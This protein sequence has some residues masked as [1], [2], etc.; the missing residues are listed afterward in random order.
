MDFVESRINDEK[1]MMEKVI[2]KEVRGVVYKLIN[3]FGKEF[4]SVKTG[5]LYNCGV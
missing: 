2:K 4:G 1:S 5:S 3:G